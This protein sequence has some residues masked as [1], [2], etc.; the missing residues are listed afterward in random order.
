MRWT[1][2]ELHRDHLSDEIRRLHAIANGLPV[3][4]AFR[5]DAD[6]RALQ[7]DIPKHLC[8]DAEDIVADYLTQ[9]V[10]EWYGLQQSQTRALFETV[11]LDLVITHPSKWTYEA[12]N[13]TVR[14]ALKAFS[15]AMFHQRRFIS[16][17]PEPEACAL[18]TAQS[19]IANHR[20]RLQAVSLSLFVAVLLFNH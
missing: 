16:L 15:P 18:Y 11:P 5:H 17:V 4:D 3:M 1:K 2:L 19:A 7:N 14:A 8:L 9:V 6:N 12:R 13:K 20:G 10:R